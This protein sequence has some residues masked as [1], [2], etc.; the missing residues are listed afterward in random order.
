MKKEAVIMI[1]TLVGIEETVE[2][3]PTMALREGV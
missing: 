1:G 3:R 2:L